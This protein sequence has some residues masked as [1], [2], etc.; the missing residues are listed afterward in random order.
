[1]KKLLSIAVLSLC[2]SNVMA[3]SAYKDCW[4][5][6]ASVGV[7]VDNITVKAGQSVSQGVHYHIQAAGLSTNGYNVEIQAE[8][9]RKESTQPYHSEKWYYYVDAAHGLKI[10]Q[11]S[12]LS[13]PAVYGNVG[14]YTTIFRLRMTSVV[15]NM[16]DCDITGYG[17]VTVIN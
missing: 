12:M 2:V 10:D 1:M 6:F 14:T 7:D 8:N 9:D 3:S 13:P 16:K 4:N 15:T 17:T 11:S 5:G